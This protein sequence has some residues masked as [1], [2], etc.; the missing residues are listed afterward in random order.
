MIWDA[1]FSTLLLAAVL[2]VATPLLLAAMGGLISET[3]GVPNITLEGSM[4]SGACAGALVGGFTGS[5]WLGLLAAIAAGALIGVLLGILHLEFGADPIIVG[6]GLNLLAGGLTIFVVYSLLG[7]KS[8]TSSLGRHQLPTLEAGP[9]AGV[10]FL[11]DVLLGQHVLTYAAF[12]VWGAVAFMLARSVF[13]THLRA[14]GQNPV[15][16]ATAGIDVKRLQY[17]AVIVCGAL[18][19][20]AGAFLSMGY[21]SNFLRDMT[22]GRGFIALAAIFL[23][24]M[25]PLGVG[26]AALAFGFFEALSIRLGNLDIPS[27]LVQTIPYIATLVGLGFFAWRETK[28]GRSD[29]L[30]PRRRRRAS[31]TGS[32]AGSG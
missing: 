6:I 24:G 20:T 29:P 12:L 26:I 1:L 7:D 21:V 18:A 25:R 10:P 22:A 14:I 30:R 23:G 8:G 4:L 17:A 31:L 9:F 3:A 5:P 13:G 16:A 11:G 15:A 27:Q 28:R 32:R 2:R 19:G